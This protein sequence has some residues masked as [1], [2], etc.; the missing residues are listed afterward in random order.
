MTAVVDN[1]RIN[2]KSFTTY[3]FNSLLKVQR[4]FVRSGKTSEVS[5][6]REQLQNLRSMIRDNENL[7]LEALAK[8]LKKPTFEAYASEVGLLYSEIN[9]TLKHIELWTKP[10]RAPTPLVLFP[11][12]SEILREPV[13]VVLII[14]PW[15]YPF[16][17][18]ISP[19]IGALAAGNSAILKPSEWAPYTSDLI[20]DLVSGAFSPELISTVTGGPSITRK[21]LAERFDHIFFTG[22]TAVGLQVA[23][24]AASQL[25]PVTLEL[26]GKSPCIVDEEF[27]LSTAARRITWS[28]FL[29]AGQTC[30]APDYLLVP[31]HRKEALVSKME[32]CIS[33]FFGPDPATSEDYARI[34]SERHFDRLLQ[35]LQPK[36]N[37]ITGGL[38]DRESLYIAPTLIDNPP[39]NSPS[40]SDEIFG[41]I[42]PILSYETIDEAIA[43]AQRHPDPL[44]L[45]IFSK[46]PK[47]QKKL[48]QE[49]PSGG[50]CVNNAVAHFVNTSLPF[51]GRRASGMGS[52]HG[53]YSFETFS[54]QR[55]ILRSSTWFDLRLRYPP[56]KGKLQWLRKLLR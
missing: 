31:R 43:Y 16:Q 10:Q 29:N 1:G 17:L 36:Q 6:R 37:I 33:T 49:I 13:G 35:F 24:H 2:H 55:A 18:V 5:Y 45:Y 38:F 32:E 53:R 14:A 28:K 54:H 47:H 42:L 30:L 51:G 11:A 15:N 3:D 12:K 9:H 41:P 56:Y 4:A 44:A 40:L 19:L 52:Y 48:L 25:T 50:V 39:D 20:A 22:S 26:G 34:V 8:D 7:I 27:A 46:N 21:I 23:K